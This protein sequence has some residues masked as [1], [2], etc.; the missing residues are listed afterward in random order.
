MYNSILSNIYTW[1]TETLGLNSLASDILVVGSI[2]LIVFLLAWLSDF[3]SKRILLRI[4]NRAVRKTKSTWDD[5]FLESHVFERIAHI[6]PAI[7]IYYSVNLIPAEY[8][9]IASFVRSATMIY[10]LLMALLM[11]DSVINS[12]YLIYQK[13]P[14]SKTRSIKGY[15]QV[16]KIAVYFIIIISILSIILNRPLTKLLTGLGALAAVLI[17]VFK[18][19]ILGF[20]A[21]IQLSANKM[22]QVGDWISI[23]KYNADGDVIDISINTVKV[24]NWDKTISTIPTYALVSDSFQNWRGM[25]ES[26]G[27]RIKRSISIDMK[28]VKFC[29]PEDLEKFRKINALQEYLSK[30][31]KELQAYNEK[32]DIDNSVLVNGRRLTNLGV[33]RA[34]VEEYLR[35][36]DKIS[37]ELTFLI[38]QLQPNDKGIPIEIYVFSKDQNWVNYEGIQSDIFDHLLAVI[39][40][41]G[42]SVFQSP[43]GEDFK[44]LVN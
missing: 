9:S 39:P 12:F 19:T 11:I 8:A 10:M 15:V 38:R 34:Y 17:L 25:T 24:R 18:D 22:V 5:I 40:E 43:T 42:L 36:N 35:R 41:F 13:Q 44:H 32:H 23:P 14:I 6:A 20:V 29:T 7:V 16:V 28:S 26:G 1:L 4:I 21:S 3:L 37:K 2:I 30:K 27:R 33:F 31:Q